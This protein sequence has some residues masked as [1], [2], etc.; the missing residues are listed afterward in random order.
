MVRLLEA[1]L[2][3]RLELE[4]RVADIEVAREAA[5]QEVEH[6]RRIRPG[7]EDDMGRHDVHPRGDGPGVEVVNVGHSGRLQD[8]PP[9]TLHVDTLGRGFAWLDTGTPTSLLQAA[10]FIET[11]E[12]RQ[13]LKIACPEEIAYNLGLINAKKLA[14][15]AEPLR[16]SGYGQYLLNILSKR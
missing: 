4:G 9:D 14:T 16:K 3:G 1:S 13:G 7:V 2:V 11:I 10:N 6:C 5:A 15:L 12:Q 8:V